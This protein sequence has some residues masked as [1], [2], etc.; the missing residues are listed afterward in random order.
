MLSRAW[1]KNAQSNPNNASISAHCVARFPAGYAMRARVYVRPY[2]T[3][4]IGVNMRQFLYNAL[5]GVVFCSLWVFCLL[6]YFDVL[7]K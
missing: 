1:R 3:G 7:T 6:S 5:C 4:L 2:A